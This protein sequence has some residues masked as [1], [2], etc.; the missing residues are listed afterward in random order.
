MCRISPIGTG[1]PVPYDQ[2]SVDPCDTCDSGIGSV[3]ETSWHSPD[4]VPTGAY[5]KSKARQLTGRQ[6]RVGGH[7][8][9]SARSPPNSR[10]AGP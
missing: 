1:K 8:V 10:E 3:Q 9:N 2:V 5:H 7:A 6:P 4:I